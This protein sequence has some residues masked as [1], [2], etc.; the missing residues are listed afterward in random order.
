MYISSK[1]HVNLILISCKSH[2]YPLANTR[3][4]SDKSQGTFQT[5][6]PRNISGKSVSVKLWRFLDES[7]SNLRYQSGK[8]K[9]YLRFNSSISHAH[10]CKSNH[11]LGIYQAYISYISVQTQ[12]H[13]RNIFRIFH[14]SDRYQ[15]TLWYI[16][17]IFH[18]YISKYIRQISYISGMF[19]PISSIF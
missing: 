14:S 4:I 17:G 1:S 19:R 9:V 5:I 16:S 12:D 3:L 15:T 10:L 13:L 11:I 2:A 6:N 7:N 18:E 8:T